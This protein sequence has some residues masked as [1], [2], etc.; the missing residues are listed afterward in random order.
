MKKNNFHAFTADLN[1]QSTGPMVKSSPFCRGDR[2]KVNN[3]LLNNLNSPRRTVPRTYL[4]SSGSES[5]PARTPS[6]PPS[7]PCRCW[8]PPRRRSAGTS[9]PRTRRC[10]RAPT[11]NWPS[12]WSRSRSSHQTTKR[13]LPPAAPGTIQNS[14][15]HR[16][17]PKHA[18]NNIYNNFTKLFFIKRDQN[19]SLVLTTSDYRKKFTAF[20]YCWY[21]AE[22]YLFTRAS[23][24]GKLH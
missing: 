2:G 13:H 10:I 18:S 7:T 16:N 24:S 11:W 4:S 23:H 19:Y 21:D 3:K 5:P 20:K 22:N 12:S 14:T 8:A 15:N 17:D 9:C 6:P 1:P